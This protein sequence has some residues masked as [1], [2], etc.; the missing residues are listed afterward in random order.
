MIL[1]GFIE[2]MDMY[3]NRHSLKIGSI[4][5]VTSFLIGGSRIRMKR[6]EC[7]NVVEP[8]DEVIDM[9]KEGA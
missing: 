6:N 9:M 7:L 1:N 5:S 4:V 3:G 2:V 8:Y